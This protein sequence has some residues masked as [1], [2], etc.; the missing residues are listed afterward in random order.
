MLSFQGLESSLLLVGRVWER[1]APMVEGDLVVGVPARDVVVVTGSR[2]VAGLAKAR[3]CVDRVFFAGG[4]QLLSADLLVRCRT[5]W[6]V[7]DPDPPGPEPDVVVYGGVRE[8]TFE[9]EAFQRVPTR[10]PPRRSR[11]G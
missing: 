10:K 6:E 3:R 5:G 1:L 8:R 7:F 9:R 11:H 4:N 2:S